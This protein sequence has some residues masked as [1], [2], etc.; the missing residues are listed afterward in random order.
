ME[1]HRHK[2]DLWPLEE[3]LPPTVVRPKTDTFWRILVTHLLKD[4]MKCSHLQKQNVHRESD[5]IL[6][7][8]KATKKPTALTA[9]KIKQILEVNWKLFY[10]PRQIIYLTLFCKSEITADSLV[11]GTISCCKRNTRALGLSL[12]KLALTHTKNAVIGK[13][14]SCKYPDDIF[15]PTLK[16]YLKKNLFLLT[17]LT[18]VLLAQG[19]S[20][21]VFIQTYQHTI[22]LAF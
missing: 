8:K 11:S 1:P 3:L 4:G 22:L 2:S 17:A 18:F 20:L 6:N 21:H 13:L 5:E 16:M 10:L 19:N 15:H 14:I 12:C 9:F 7:E